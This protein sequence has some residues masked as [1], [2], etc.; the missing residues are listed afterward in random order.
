VHFTHH[1]QQQSSLKNIKLCEHNSTD[2]Q[3]AQPTAQH[4]Q[5]HSNTSISIGVSTTSSQSLLPQPQQRTTILLGCRDCNSSYHQNSH[6]I[7][8]QLQH[9]AK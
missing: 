9:S 1:H 6:H 2:Q 3:A 4:H 5:Q 7:N 8:L